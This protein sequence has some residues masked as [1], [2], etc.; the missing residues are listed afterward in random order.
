M[1]RSSISQYFHHIEIMSDKKEQQYVQLLKHLDI[2]PEAF[3][4]IG[5]SLK[6]DIMPSLELG[7]WGI[8][9]P[10]HTTWA[11]EEVDREPDSERYYKVEHLHQILDL[12]PLAKA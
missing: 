7:S 12:I 11:H 4:M 3:L 10:Y 5:N 2:A 9:V 6:S 1:T 8:Y